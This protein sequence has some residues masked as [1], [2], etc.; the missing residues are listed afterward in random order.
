MLQ[1]AVWTGLNQAARG[2]GA[3]QGLDWAKDPKAQH[4]LS[5]AGGSSAVKDSTAAAVASEQIQQHGGLHSMLRHA[6][7]GSALSWRGPPGEAAVIS[8]PLSI[9]CHSAE[10]A[11]KGAHWCQRWD[12]DTCPMPILD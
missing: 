10:G 2:N 7:M 9:L 8:M 3:T 6:N 1:R 5:G 11:Y 4:S 12:M